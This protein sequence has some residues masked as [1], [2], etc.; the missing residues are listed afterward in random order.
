MSAED[1]SDDKEHEAS[2]HKLEEARKRGEIPQ[3][4]DLLAAAALA[5]L[6]LALLGLGPQS[7]DGFGVMSVWLIEQ[8][9]P[10]SAGMFRNST[11]LLSA[12]LGQVTVTGGPLLAV[13][14]LAVLAMVTLQRLFV[15]SPSKLAPK[16]SRISPIQGAKNKFGRTGLFDFA[17][18]TVKL[19]VISVG[20]GMFLSLRLDTVMMSVD[21]RPFDSIALMMRL[22]VEFIGLV[23]V[24]QLLVG[25]LDYL[26]QHKEHLR[27][28]RMSRK[29]MMDEFKNSE[30]DPHMKAERRQR[31]V[32][33]SSNQMLADV[34]QADVIIVNPT[35][36]AVALKWS[37]KSAGAPVCLA[38]GVDEIAARIREQAIEHG[39]PM[40]SD[41]PT[42]RALFATVEVGEEIPKET[43]RAVAAAIRF[44]EAMRAKAKAR[45]SLKRGGRA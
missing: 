39:I 34:K 8:A 40:H 28:N 14:L 17:K 35:H 18:N 16:L 38:K 12:I 41:P 44:A 36:Y 1:D 43:Y 7:A 19:G 21:L 13:P 23:L 29:E 27:K 10:V 30:G 2:A 37:R 22:L 26:F 33:I 45:G 32:E 20:L 15:F 42:A 25:G 11:P 24:F 9:D 3:G 31:G 5:G 6:L 4:K